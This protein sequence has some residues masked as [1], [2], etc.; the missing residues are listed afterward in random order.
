MKEDFLHYIWQHQ[1]FAKADL[2]T[3][4]GQALQVLRVGFYNTDAGPDF[5]EALLRVGEV[6]WSGS[7]EVHLNASDWHRHQHQHD[8]KYDQVVLH[9]VWEADVP[10]TRTDGTLVPVLELQQRV[11]LRLLQTYEMLQQAKNPIPCA[12]F[13]PEVPEITKK[14]MLERALVERLEEKGEQVL[15]SYRSYGNDWEQATYEALLRSFGFKINQAPFEQLAKALPLPVVRRH[16]QNLLQLEALLLGQAGFLAD[17]ADAYAQQLQRE[18]TFLSHKYNLQPLA[19]QRHQWNFLRM[20]PAN[21]PTVRLAQ[22]AALLHQQQALFSRLLEADTVKKYE[23]LFQA[24]VSAYWQR[25]YLFGRENKAPATRMGK[26]SAQNLIINIAVPLLA[27]C[28]NF[29]GENTYLERAVSL[30]E[31]L[32][33]S[34]NKYTRL[35]EALRWHAKS[36]ADNQAALSLYKRYCQP[37]NCMHCAVGNKIMKQNSSA[38]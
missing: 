22:L 9:V 37:V 3:T 26:S 2:A 5:R 36:A 25:H 7:V 17:A 11:D 15:Q 38:A 30:L 31:Q 12:A 18:Y 19:L 32:R 35:Y 34:S 20:R 6:E 8:Q 24:P 13:W 29:S 10:V 27:A 21:F 23:Q 16:Q 1:Y 4:D 28:A 33:E 14:L